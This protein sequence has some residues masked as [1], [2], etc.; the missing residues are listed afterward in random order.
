MALNNSH[1]TDYFAEIEPFVFE[2]EQTAAAAEK[3]A[4]KAC[5]RVNKQYCEI[6]QQVSEATKQAESSELFELATNVANHT[7]SRELKNYLR[8]N[9]GIMPNKP[10]AADANADAEQIRLKVATE[11]FCEFYVWHKLGLQWSDAHKLIFEPQ[12][13]QEQAIACLL[14]TSPSPRDGLLSRMPSSA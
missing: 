5:K 9:V 11:A 6:E 3:A 14:Y 8:A 2:C 7:P 4:N 13:Q 12:P 10:T 1:L